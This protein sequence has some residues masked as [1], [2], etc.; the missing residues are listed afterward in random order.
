MNTTAINWSNIET[1]QPASSCNQFAHKVKLFTIHY[2]LFTPAVIYRCQ[3][4]M[5]RRMAQFIDRHPALSNLW[6]GGWSLA[7]IIY[8]MMYA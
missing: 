4:R 5:Y 2:K 1:V 8:V 3:L 7:G 6:L